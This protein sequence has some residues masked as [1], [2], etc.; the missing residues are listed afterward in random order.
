MEG[1]EVHVV[2][3]GDWDV[4]IV[5]GSVP[6]R[7]RGVKINPRLKE[8]VAISCLV[9]GIRVSIYPSPLAGRLFSLRMRL[10]RALPRW[11]RAWRGTFLILRPLDALICFVMERCYWVVEAVGGEIG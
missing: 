7:G 2:R 3:S 9:K 11:L 1:G 5:L 6:P 4:E 10:V 8:D